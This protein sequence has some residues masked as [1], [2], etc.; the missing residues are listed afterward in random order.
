MMNELIM[1]IAEMSNGCAVAPADKVLEALKEYNKKAY[2][3][4][5]WALEWGMMD[6]AEA[7][8]YLRKEVW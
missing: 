7:A 2:D 5:K 1:M 3:N 6:W 4:V 8:E